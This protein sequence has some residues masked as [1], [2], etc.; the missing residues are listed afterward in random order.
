M[1]NSS[2]SRPGTCSASVHPHVHG[3]LL[4]G[5]GVVI[6]AIGSSPRAWGTP[7]FREPENL[8]GRFIPTCM[9]NSNRT[10]RE[11]GWLD[12]YNPTCMGNSPV[13]T[14]R[15]G[16]DIR[17]IPTCMGELATRPA[18]FIDVD[19]SSPRAWG[20]PCRS[21]SFAGACGF[22]PTCMGN[23]STA[24]LSSLRGAVHPHVHGEL[25]RSPTSSLHSSGSSP[26]AWGTQW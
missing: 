8:R 7:E 24:T 14:F 15:P 17:F 18:L 4:C 26:R 22:I 3:E 16:G 20:T 25:L 23:S 21:A 12:G 13:S 11:R 6:C 10:R 9:G 19:G 1:G 5:A 2:G